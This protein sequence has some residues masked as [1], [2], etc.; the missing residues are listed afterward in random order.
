[1]VDSLGGRVSRQLRELCQLG[2]SVIPSG[3]GC[4]V[5]LGDGISRLPIPFG[6]RVS[7][8]VPTYESVS[9]TFSYI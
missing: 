8:C 1:M 9:M 3:L 7:N 6:K 2:V 4:R 5:Q